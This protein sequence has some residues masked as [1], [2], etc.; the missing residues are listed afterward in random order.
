M[1]FRCRSIAHGHL[2]AAGAHLTDDNEQIVQ[3]CTD[4][5]NNGQQRQHPRHG[6]NLVQRAVEPYKWGYADTV[7]EKIEILALYIGLE[8]SPDVSFYIVGSCAGCKPHIAEISV[9]AHPV[10]AAIDGEFRQCGQ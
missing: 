2:L 10:V 7:V 5:Q 8:H 1:P 6:L 3:P 9:V 4:K